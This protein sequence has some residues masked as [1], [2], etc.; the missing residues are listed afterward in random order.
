MN[1]LTWLAAGVAV[2]FLA[3]FVTDSRG[4]DAAI[5]LGV[6]I[7]GALLG[8]LGV[9]PLMGAYHDPMH[10][11]LGHAMIAVAVAVI[12]LAIVNLVRKGMMR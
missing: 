2:G 4:R 12:L 5:N 9:S 11:G 8:G 7:V 6:G 10:V 3:N 1:I